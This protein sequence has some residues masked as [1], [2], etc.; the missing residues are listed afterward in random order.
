[1]PKDRTGKP[2]EA[3]GHLVRQ[4]REFL[5]TSQ[6]DLADAVGV[7][8]MSIRRIEGGTQTPRLAL[9]IRLAKALRVGM[10]EDLF[11]YPA[12]DRCDQ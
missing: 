3:W 12:I 11:P 9:M 4:R 5:K 7:S 10:I 2:P 6:Q 1:M 8:V